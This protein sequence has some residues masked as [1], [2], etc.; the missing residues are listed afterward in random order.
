[1]DFFDAVPIL[2]DFMLMAIQLPDL[3]ILQKR[4]GGAMA[5]EG[6]KL[7]LKINTKYYWG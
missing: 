4:V 1:M 2:D 7:K 5:W 6:D 3:P